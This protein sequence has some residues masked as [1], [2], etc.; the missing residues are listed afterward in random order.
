MTRGSVWGTASS[1][2]LDSI[3]AALANSA[4]AN[5]KM[6]PTGR[7]NK[8]LIGV[9]RANLPPLT[10]KAITP[11]TVTLTLRPILDEE[12]P[13]PAKAPSEALARRILD[14]MNRLGMNTEIQLETSA[15][16]H[17]RSLRLALPEMRAKAD[18]KADNKVGKAEPP[19]CVC[20]PY[21]APCACAD[22]LTC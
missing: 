7:A 11:T 9:S 13:D 22:R 6:Y 16:L 19:S 18:S 14:T 21:H 20:V 1:S 5:L 12:P 10:N 2:D 15:I 17:S 8:H 4:L 3:P